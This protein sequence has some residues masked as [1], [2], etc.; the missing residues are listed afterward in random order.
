MVRPSIYARARVC[1]CKRERER[2]QEKR[3]KSDH[4]DFHIVFRGFSLKY[5]CQ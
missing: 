2:E 5:H 4:S 3:V 1:V